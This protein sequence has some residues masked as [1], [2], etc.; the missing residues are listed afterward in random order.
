MRQQIVIEVSI[1]WRHLIAAVEPIDTAIEGHYYRDFLL[2][3]GCSTHLESTVSV[4]IFLTCVNSLGASNLSEIIR[5]VQLPDSALPLLTSTEVCVG[6]ASRQLCL[7]AR[8][9]AGASLLHTDVGPG[10]HADS[11]FG[12]QFGERLQET[13]TFI[14]LNGLPH[15]PS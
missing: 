15:V 1:T 8:D 7:C 3:M 9:T 14:H 2:F 6:A 13:V 10:T 11:P 12:E 4:E 5:H